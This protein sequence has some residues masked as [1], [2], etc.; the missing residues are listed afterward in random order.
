MT[1]FKYI[2]TICLLSVALFALAQ[3]K[4]I[5]EAGLEQ[6]DFFDPTRTEKPQEVYQFGIAYHL[7]AGYAQ[8]HQRMTSDT[9]SALYLHGARLGAQFEMFLP[10]HFSLNIG[11]LYSIQYGISRQHYHT[12]SVDNPQIE[13][14]NNHILEHTLTIPIRAQYTIPLWKQ[15]S[16]H[17]Y[18]GPQLSVGLAQTDYVKADLSPET[19]A[20]LLTQ[21]KHLQ[22]Y[23]KYVT[24][25]LFRTNIQYGLGGGF[26]W[27]KYRLEAGYD[28][29]L[30]NLIRT[31]A[32]SKDRMSE[33]Q[34]HVSF[35]YT[36]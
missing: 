29:G 27:D 26:T 35:V 20:W 23:D 6:R 10:K 3:D 11:L 34:W 5:R 32:N 19:A 18:T 16:M 14:V 25:E 7:E 28:F 2:L 9:I 17:F 24:K 13:V 15:L 36:L 31:S 12:A 1:R 30:N 8:N 22:T 4:L 33:W 21:G